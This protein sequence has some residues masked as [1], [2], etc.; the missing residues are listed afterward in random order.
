LGPLPQHSGR[1]RFRILSIS[2]TTT[3]RPPAI[4]YFFP[5]ILSISPCQV[6][7]APVPRDPRAALRAVLD[8]M[9]AEEAAG[10]RRPALLL[11]LLASAA[12]LAAAAAARRARGKDT[13]NDNE[14]AKRK[15]E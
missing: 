4:S 6:L 5:R 3:L 10:G 11:A 8:R 15:R 13:F 2:H 12:L 1:R 7:S 14:R 9:D